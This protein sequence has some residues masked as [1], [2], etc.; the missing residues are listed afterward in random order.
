MKDLSIITVNYR[1]WDK[2]AQ[3]LD[4]LAAITESYFTFEVIV[5]DNASNDGKLSNFKQLYPQFNF[6]LNEGNYGFANGNNRGAAAARGKYLLFLNP[7]AI[8]SEKALLAMHDQAKVSRANS[9]ISC[10]QIREN[11]AEDKPYGSFPSPLTLT[12]W[13]RALAKLL[14]LNSKI[15]QNERLVFP[16]W[17]SGSVVMMSYTSFN[18]IG[19]WNESFWMYYE[20]VDLCQRARALGGA[21]ILLKSVAVIHK[22]GGS[23]RVDNETTALTKA[24]VNISRHAYLSLHEKGLKNIFMQLFLMIDNMLFGLLTAIPGLFL[25][26]NKRL[27]TSARVYFKMMNYYLSS[28]ANYTWISPRSVLHPGNVVFEKRPENEFIQMNEN[29]AQRA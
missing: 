25:F 3:C 23:S 16:D 15:R 24:E 2:L 7:D 22:H 12:G 1:S 29:N 26:F 10:R 8:I 20:D 19:K 6:I 17:V 21:V 28:L 11:G 27:N 9:I 5:V 18:T 4:S 13:T 14:N